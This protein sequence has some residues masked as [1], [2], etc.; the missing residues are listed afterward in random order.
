M[1]V[2]PPPLCLAVC[3]LLLKCASGSIILRTSNYT[4]DPLEDM[5][6]NFGPRIPAEGIEGFLIVADPPTACSKL[7][8]PVTPVVSWVALIQR[9]QEQ[10]DQCTFD[11]KVQNARQ[12]GAIAAII[13]DDTFGPLIIMSKPLGHP[14][15][16]I[17]AVFVAQKTGIVMQKF[18]KTGTVTV[19]IV[20]VT[21][22][23]WV[24]ML[25]SA[26]AGI[27]AVCLM[28]ATFYC[29]RR[30]RGFG[31]AGAAGYQPLDGCADGMSA[32]QMRALPVVI[33]EKRSCRRAGSDGSTDGSETGSDE[34]SPLG[35]KGGGTLKTCAICLEDYR[36][37][38]KL[39]VLPCN[40]RFHTECID[41]WLSSRKPLCP[42]C[43]HDALRPLGEEEAEAQGQED[44]ETVAED[45]RPEL[46]LPPFFFPINRWRRRW[47]WG[48][49]PGHPQATTSALD[50][51][52]A[53]VDIEQPAPQTQQGSQIDAGASS[54]SSHSGLAAPAVALGTTHF[55][56]PGMHYSRAAANAL[57]TVVS[58]DDITAAADD[59]QGISA[60]RDALQRRAARTA[61]AL[62]SIRTHARRPGRARSVRRPYN[63]TQAPDRP[64]HADDPVL[65]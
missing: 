46:S 25:M 50:T 42:V 28:I 51:A 11:R 61:A 7:R 64:H 1:F 14:D 29:I 20:Q 8:V 19:Q 65:A 9:S 35:P 38:E 16:A 43:K 27:L 18:L 55:N 54:S 26:L 34:G 10:D 60:D 56:F 22:A 5:P 31:P 17:P 37:G 33:A 63:R 53:P 57:S 41:Q 23:V 2:R 59:V 6:A 44:A 62:P 3:L 24:S 36:D 13:Y 12:A 45:P 15:P 4:F 21:D 39:R 48:P 30:Q 32:E 52:T 58:S 47:Q 40:H 49:G